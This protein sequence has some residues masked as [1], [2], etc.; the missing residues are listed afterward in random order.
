MCQQSCVATGH[1]GVQVIH[2][3]VESELAVHLISFDNVDAINEL[4]ERIGITAELGVFLGEHLTQVLRQQ[5]P[6][7]VIQSIEFLRAGDCSADGSRTSEGQII[8]V[9]SLCIP[10]DTRVVLVSNSRTH[11]LNLHVRI[12]ANCANGKFHIKT[13]VIVQRQSIA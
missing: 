13:D 12:I 11:D 10:I 6:D 7:V 4:L 2:H 1:C 8:Q 3:E 9:D 5:H